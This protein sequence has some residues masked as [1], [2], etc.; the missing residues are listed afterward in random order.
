[1]NDYNYLTKLLLYNLV[2]LLLGNDFKHS[3]HQQNNLAPW[4]WLSHRK[5]CKCDQALSIFFFYKGPGNKARHTIYS[6]INFEMSDTFSQ[7]YWSNLNYTIVVVC[8]IQNQTAKCSPGTRT[9]D[10]SFWR[11]W[12]KSADNNTDPSTPRDNLYATLSQT[13]F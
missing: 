7:I 13:N 3:H 12:S 10:L 8:L 1:M 5:H 11:Q 2:Q 6:L 9:I 4:Q